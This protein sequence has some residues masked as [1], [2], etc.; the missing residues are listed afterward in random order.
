[1][2]NLIKKINDETTYECMAC[3]KKVKLDRKARVVCDSCGS[4]VLFKLRTNMLTE[5]I[6]R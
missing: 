3:K 1:M 2:E 6:C 5:Y 4:R